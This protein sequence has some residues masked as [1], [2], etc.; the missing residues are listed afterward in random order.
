MSRLPGKKVIEYKNVFWYI[1]QFL[2]IKFIVLRIQRYTDINVH[3]SSCKVSVTL[4]WF[5][6]TLIF[7]TDF[8]KIPK[9]QI[10]GKFVQWEPSCSMRTDGQIDKMTL[11]VAFRNFAKASNTGNTYFVH[12]QGVQVYSQKR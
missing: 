2:S 8:R 1:L 11:I 12:M 5:N 10:S 9:H 7:Y 3:M 6:E 4:A